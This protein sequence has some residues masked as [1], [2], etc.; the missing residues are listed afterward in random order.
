M[1]KEIRKYIK[2]IKALIS[3]NSKEEKTFIKQLEKQIQQ[4]YSNAEFLDYN[5]LVATYG[6][7]N[8]VATSYLEI[9]DPDR[10]VKYFKVKKRIASSIILLMVFIVLYSFY[11]VYNENQLY[12]EARKSLHL[13][14]E[15]TITESTN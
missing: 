7:P 15:T 11:Q 2:S 13:H 1:E 5:G 3:L 8:E 14:E 6:T 10:F 4:S 12:I 9:Q